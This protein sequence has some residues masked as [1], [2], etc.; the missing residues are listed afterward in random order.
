MTTHNY[1][2]NNKADNKADNEADNEASNEASN[3]ANNI[4]KRLLQVVSE[5]STHQSLIYVGNLKRSKRRQRQIQ[6]EAVVRTSKLES[7]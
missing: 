1:N 3:E 4:F 7:F 6:R 2:A 5:V